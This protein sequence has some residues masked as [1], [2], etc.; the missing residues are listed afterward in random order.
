MEKYT[1]LKD[2][3]FQKYADLL[4]ASAFDFLFKKQYFSAYS[5]LLEGL[6]VA[7]SDI[8]IDRKVQSK[9]QEV[10]DII[11]D[12]DNLNEKS[13]EHY[14]LLIILSITNKKQNTQKIEDWLEVLIKLEG[15]KAFNSYL[16]GKFLFYRDDQAAAIK[17]FNEID[18]NKIPCSKLWSGVIKETLLYRRGLNEICGIFMSDPSCSYALK[19]LKKHSLNHM[20]YNVIIDTSGFM[21]KENE[22]IQK[23]LKNDYD[24]D[25][26]EKEY[27]FQ[28]A[29]RD[30]L[31]EGDKYVKNIKGLLDFLRKNYHK[32]TDKLD[33]CESYEIDRDPE[34]FGLILREFDEIK[35]SYDISNTLK[36]HEQSQESLEESGYDDEFDS[37]ANFDE[38]SWYSGEEMYNEDGLRNTFRRERYHRTWRID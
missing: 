2:R 16:I 11:N 27:N 25:E 18:N 20:Y 1:L 29:N 23:F 33:L 6:E 8:F 10:N 4:F 12:I 9:N 28:F 37:A 13:I 21:S 38:E 14:F 19:K 7:P 22:L 36:R 30:H 34:L 5:F 3:N 15:R 24:L 32:F 31:F 35:S 26:F 17:I